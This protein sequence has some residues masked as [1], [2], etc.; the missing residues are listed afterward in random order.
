MGS[1]G[2]VVVDLGG[3]NGTLLNGQRLRVNIETPFRPGDHLR[4]GPYELLV[5][6]PA[7]EQTATP[8]PIAE[9]PTPAPQATGAAAALALFLA[10]DRLPAAPGEAATFHVEVA[11]RSQLEDRVTVLVEGLPESWVTAP[12]DFITVPAGSRVPVT[13]EIHVPRQ[14]ARPAGRQRFRVLLRSQQ[15]PDEAPAITASL[16]L[17]T[18]E[19]FEASLV[20]QRVS[21]PDTVQ[22]RILNTG[23]MPNSF[24]IVGRDPDQRIRF[25][26]E[27]GQIRLEP[28]QTAAVDL[29]LDARTS[30][31]FSKAEPHPYAVEVTNRAGA[32]QMVSGEALI[33]PLVP[34]WLS[35]TALTLVVF[36]CVF[37]FLFLVFG[38]TIRRPRGVAAT[39]AAATT[40]AVAQADLQTIIA[41][42]ATIDAATRLA[43]TPTSTG[44]ADQDG[45]SD[46]QEALLGTSPEIADTDGDG[47]LDGAEVLDLG[48]NPLARDT[49]GDFLNDWDE[50]NVYGTL[51]N[52]PDTDGDGLSDGLEVTQGTNPLSGATATP[53][54]TSTLAPPVTM[55]LEPGTATATATV[56]ATPSATTTGTQTA[57]P[58]PTVVTATPSPTASPTPT[59]TPSPTLTSTPTSTPS[60]TPEPVVACIQA[61]PVADGELDDT[62]WALGPMVTLPGVEYAASVFVVKETSGLYYGFSLADS[63]PSTGDGLRLYLD[64]NGNLGDPDV[65]DRLI[66]ISRN[67]T[68]L[69]FRGIGN[70]NDGAAWE[71]FSSDQI[72]VG[73]GEVAGNGW[74]AEVSILQD[75]Q[76]V[77]VADPFGMMLEVIDGGATLLWPDDAEADDAAT[78]TPIENP[79]CPPSP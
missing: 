24:A 29:A 35:Y 64:L 31:W 60:A 68:F 67:G 20:P 59:F 58:S 1:N 22:V 13:I 46:R 56:T 6:A 4:V 54:A 48:C 52:N 5:Q 76:V 9:A 78:W 23:N 75:A 26:G 57:T 47:L 49:D 33:A 53:A 8:V 25:Q 36:V 72:L 74:S 30:N 66:E 71:P 50:V 39:S 51:C 73:I 21:L 55:T 70:N 16:M 11:N 45:L 12:T 15:F 34:P 44:D 63:T 42:T 77:G 17:G 41:A 14:V 32:R 69:V 19:S 37:S 3:I 27:R 62:A 43:I 2:W 40:T 65:Q 79:P 10:R 18:L 7:T 28:G 38:D 61:P